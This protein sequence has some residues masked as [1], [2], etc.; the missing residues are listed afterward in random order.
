M[1]KL[2]KYFYVT[3]LFVLFLFADLLASNYLAN[4]YTDLNISNKYM[5][6]T[7]IRNTGAAFSLLQ[8]SRELLIILSVVALTLIAVYIVRHIKA[9]R[10]L[11]LFLISILSAG[12]AGNLHERIALGFVRD[13]FHLKFINFPV[14][15]ISDIMINIGVI[16]IALLILLKKTK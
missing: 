11:E 8:N 10:Y 15:N 4:N 9:I 16:F 7:Y 12:I 14:F 5:S 13:F 2:S 3:V 1:Q 6:L